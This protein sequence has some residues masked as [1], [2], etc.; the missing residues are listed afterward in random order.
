MY[1]EKLI[2]APT[3]KRKNAVP[4]FHQIAL[5]DSDHLVRFSAFQALVLMSE[6]EGVA[7][8]L[9]EIKNNEKDKRL[10]ELYEKI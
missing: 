9:E 3:E 2:Q 10:I 8:A 7:A 5:N 1:A 6:I 4:K